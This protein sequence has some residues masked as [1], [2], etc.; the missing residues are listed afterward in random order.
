M[1]RTY[2]Y[3]ALRTPRGKGTAPREGKAGGALAS[4]PPQHLVSQLVDALAE[5]H[6]KGAMASVAQ[7]LLGCVGQVGS[8]GGHLALVSRIASSLPETVAPKTLNNY[9]VSG[10]TAVIEA[11]LRSRA[12][13]AGLSLAGGVEMLSQVPF[14]AD[15]AAYYADPATSAQLN[16]VAPIMGA[17]LIATEE[18]FTKAD[19]DRLTL[20]SHQRAAAAWEAGKYDASVIPVRDRDGVTLL[21]HDELVR[22]GLSAEQLESMPPA[23]AELGQAGQDQRVL[24][25][26][27]NLSAIDHV[28]SI[29]N[30]PGMADGAALV[31]TGSAEA[32]QSVGLRPRARVLAVAETAGDPV[33]QFG[34]GFAAMEQAL[35]SA[36]LELAQLDRIEFMEAFA[37]VPLRFERRFDVDPERINVNGGHL[38]MGHPMGATGAIL[39]CTL[40]NELEQ[41]DTGL[42]MAVALAGGGIGSAMI[43]ERA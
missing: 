34:A 23:F 26:R 42:G 7:L 19:L 8:Q 37:A 16:W 33:L 10:M 27:P 1:T 40:L 39:L 22:P 21:A 6:D 5:R 2:I 38:A 4:V 41:S 18:G 13:D 9:C 25:H 14:Q 31:L 43:I 11:A 30:C 29:A 24:D 15:K 20:R 3:D 28:H 17:E 35:E 12:G 32:G 36:G